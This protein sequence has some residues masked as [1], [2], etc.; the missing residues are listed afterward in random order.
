MEYYGLPS[1]LLFPSSHYRFEISD[2]KFELTIPKRG[3]YKDLDEEYFN[4]R[5]I[6]FDEF[7]VFDDETSTFYPPAVTTVLLSLKKYPKL[8][9]GEVFMP[10]KFE[11]KEKDIVIVGIIAK[12]LSSEGLESEE[13]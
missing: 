13:A 4:G 2:G 11:I 10:L 1:M 3:I 5:D 7:V 12:L 6:E 8:S 9:I